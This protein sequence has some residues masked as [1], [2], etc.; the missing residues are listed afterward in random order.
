M[1][2]RI[3]MNDSGSLIIYEGTEGQPVEVR[4]DKETLWLSLN[5]I[6]ALFDRDKSSISRHIKNIFQSGELASPSVVANFA[7]TADDGKTYQVDYFN[8][9]LIISVGYRVNSKRGTQFRIWATGVLRDHL[10]K[11]YSLNER[12]L[13]ERDR[14]IEELRTSIDLLQ[15]GLRAAT[16]DQARSMAIILADFADGFKLLDDYDH[17]SLDKQG[18]TLRLSHHLDYGQAMEVID[19]MRTDFDSEVFGREKDDS[20]RS[21][22]GQL[23]QTFN[24][25]E[26]YPSIEEKAAVLLFLVVKNHSFVDGNKRIAAALFL[27]FLEK[28]GLLYQAKGKPLLTGNGLAG[29]T[30]MI[31][32]GKTEQMEVMVRVVVSVLCRVN[33]ELT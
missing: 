33:R 25:K 4:L 12:K 28:N 22:L 31:A 5:Q 17:D 3:D 9:D 26:L 15:S 20:L 14:A 10:A 32:E 29:L 13:K 19:S 16:I 21:S 27:Y 30:L 7:T 18:A 2:R 23:Y 6:A 1:Q 11:G 8:L 24:G